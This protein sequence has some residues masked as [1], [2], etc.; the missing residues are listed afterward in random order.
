MPGDVTDE[1]YAQTLVDVALREFGGLDGALNNAGFM[2]TGEMV[3]DAPVDRWNGVLATNLTAGYHA[4]RA[5]IPALGRGAAG[6][7]SLP[8]RS[9]A[10]A[11][12]CREWGLMRPPKPDWSDWFRPSRSKTGP[13]GIRANVLMPGST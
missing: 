3:A 12:H 10:T 7:W 2:G 4:A 11:R 8:A 9:L 5:Q 13:E 1:T 6:R